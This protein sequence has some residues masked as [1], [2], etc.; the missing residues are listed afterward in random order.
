[1]F[2]PDLDMSIPN[3]YVLKRAKQVIEWENQLGAPIFTQENRELILE[4]EN[5]GSLAPQAMQ[6]LSAAVS[7][8]IDWLAWAG[9][10]GAY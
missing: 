8:A 7:K 5:N 1:M 3:Q 6:Q 10:W 2:K 4:L 9:H